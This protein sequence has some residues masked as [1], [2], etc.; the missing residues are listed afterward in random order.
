MTRHRLFAGSKMPKF[1]SIITANDARDIVHYLK[2]MQSEKL[3]N[4]PSYS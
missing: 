1:E 3:I 2:Q 4:P